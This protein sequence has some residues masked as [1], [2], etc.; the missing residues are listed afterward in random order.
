LWLTITPFGGP[1]VPLV[2]EKVKQSSDLVI[3][4]LL[5]TSTNLSPSSIKSE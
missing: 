5:F 1:V 2:Y 3:T 4:W